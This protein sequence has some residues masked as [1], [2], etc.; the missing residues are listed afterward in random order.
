MMAENSAFG[1]IK[2]IVKSGRIPHSFMIE[3]GSFDERLDYALYLAKAIVC[4][5]ENK[6]CGN[7]RQCQI[8]DSGSN[9]DIAFLEPED[10]KK[11]ISVGQIRN[12]R[13]DAFVLPHSAEKKVYII[14]NAE[15]MNEQAQN[16]FLKILEE[17]PK[18]VVF[19][20]LTESRTLQ[21]ETVVSRC[22][23]FTL[24]GQTAEEGK[25]AEDAKA[26]L[27]LLF[28]GKNYELLK[29]FKPYEKD[30]LKAE[31]LFKALKQECVKNAADT[32]L[33][34]YRRKT[35]SEIFEETEKYI[36]LIKN[37]I[38]MSL[39]FSAVVCKFGSLIK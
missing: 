33:S 4:T 10:K 21:L 7:C 39:L 12:L 6:P 1:N 29:L 14:K 32:A 30:R 24:S 23:I 2:A 17:P 25:F 27:Q 31:K 20:L 19:I 9:V 13:N 22:S 26:V 37:N 16:A 3:G 34:N 28:D 35:V 36:G 11:F 38:N 8:T 5:G 15:L 18:S